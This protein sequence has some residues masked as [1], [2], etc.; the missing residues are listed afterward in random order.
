MPYLVFSD[1]TDRDPTVLA[2]DSTLVETIIA[3]VEDHVER[4]TQ[5]VWLK[6]AATATL[7]YSPIEDVIIDD[8]IGEYLF[9]GLDNWLGEISTVTNGDGVV[10]AADEFVLIPEVLPHYGIQILDS[11]GKS[12][13]HSGNHQE[14]IEIVGYWYHTLGVPGDLFNAMIRHVLFLYRTRGKGKTDSLPRWVTNKYDELREP[15]VFA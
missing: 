12:W 11:A 6:P 13:T 7:N 15:G 5:R 14:S 2:A 1:I 4:Y 3:E 9:L 10:V 8:L